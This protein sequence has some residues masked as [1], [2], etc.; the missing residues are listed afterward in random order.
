MRKPS[1]ALVSQKGGVG[2]TTLALNLG[3]ALAQLG[4][5]TTVVELDPQGSMGSSL[6]KSRT[7]YQGLAEILAG[8]ATVEEAR[9]PTK[10]GGLSLLPVGFVDPFE[11]SRFEAALSGG[12]LPRV[13]EQ[14]HASGSEII[15]CDCPSGLGVATLAAL[16]SV[17]HALVPIQAEPLSLRLVELVLE[18]LERIRDTSNPDLALLGLVL[19]MFDTGCDASLSVA[20]ATWQSFDPAAVLETV[21]PRR[22]VYLEASL[23]GVPVGYMGGGR[24]PEGRRF[25][26]LGQ[27]VLHRLEP[28]EEEVP[29]GGPVQTLL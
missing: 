14:V 3:L 22:R 12:N 5:S 11:I 24:H 25:H 20:Q 13:L 21:I 4:R 23:H 17:S 19:C 15:L 1:V 6:L 18:T 9:I 2:K 7:D 10:V 29:D 28:R 16:G 27:E 26:M 8:A